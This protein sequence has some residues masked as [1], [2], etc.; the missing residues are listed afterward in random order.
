MT[1][2]KTHRTRHAQP[3]IQRY[4][5]KSYI[6]KTASLSGDRLLGPDTHNNEVMIQVRVYRWMIEKFRRNSC[7]LTYRD[8]KISPECKMSKLTSLYQTYIYID[9]WLWCLYETLA[10]IWIRN[11]LHYIYY[12]GHI[13]S[14]HHSCKKSR[15]QPMR[16]GVM[17]MIY[18]PLPKFN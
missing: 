9:W 12:S 5:R 6:G 13:R 11:K 1:Q 17:R 4:L 3:N 2:L 18:F 15:H 16:N 7:Q 14:F 8:L 10:L